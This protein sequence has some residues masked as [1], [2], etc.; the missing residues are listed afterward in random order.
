MKIKANLKRFLSMSR[1][2]G[3]FTLVELIVVIAILAILAGVAI[4]AY[5][6]YIT[7]AN[8]AADRQL[9][10]AINR[11][12]AAACNTNGFS[13][14][15]VKTAEIAVDAD[16]KLVS[17]ARAAVNYITKAEKQDGTDVKDV[18]NESFATFFAGNEN[19][20][21]KTVKN[22]KLPF[23]NGAFGLPGEGGGS[24]KVTFG[25][26]DFYISQEAADKLANSTFG[27]KI[28]SDALLGKVDIVSSIAS[29]LLVDDD[30]TYSVIEKLI[31]G[32]DPDNP[33]EAYKEA[34]AAQLNMHIDDLNGLLDELEAEDPA[35]KSQFL[36]NSLVLSAAKNT[37]GMDTSFLGAAGFANEL[38]SNLS[39]PAKAQDALAQ[40]ALAYGM[41][42]AYANSS[43][44]ND[45]L[46]N[47]VANME[48]SN[49]FSGMTN[50]LGDLEDPNFKAYMESDEGKADLEAYKS[51]MSIINESANQSPEA[52]TSILENG[53]QDEELSGLLNQIMGK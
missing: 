37:E 22:Q 17:N 36:A 39:D 41:Y 46:K 49:G 3:G 28:G 31:Y 50:M 19:A 15:D 32:N 11:A 14:L 35:A 6:G 38:K 9:L 40:A 18:L 52:A 27:E 44:G 12:F 16:G 53:F 26:V 4:P 23:A 43:F 24:V 48:T 34:L 20:A 10:S 33:S 1:Q 29:G 51:A 45:T 42:N 13:P 47:N 25:G 21:F 2:N 30:S 5:S 7:K 8:E